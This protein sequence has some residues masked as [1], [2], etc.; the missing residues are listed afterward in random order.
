MNSSWYLLH[1]DLLLGLFFGTE[2]EGGIFFR[3]V[4]LLS[5]DYTAL[6]AIF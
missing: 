1:A 5:T 3:T 6:Y 2:D 4:D